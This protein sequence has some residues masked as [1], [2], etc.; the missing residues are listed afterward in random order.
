MT[1]TLLSTPTSTN[2]T[3]IP[4]T[5]WIKPFLSSLFSRPSNTSDDKKNPSVEGILPNPLVRSRKRSTVELADIFK[6]YG[7]A[8]LRT[9]TL[10]RQQ[11]KVLYD[12]THCKSAAVGYHLDVCDGCGHMEIVYNSCRNRHCPKCQRSKRHAWVRARLDQLLPIPYYHTVFTL[13]HRIFPLSLYNKEIVY[14]LL[15]ESA[16]KTLQ[17][18]ASDPKHLGAKIGFYGILHTWGGALWQH[19]HVHFIVT[20]GGLNKKGE[21]VEPKYKDK[22]LF[23]VRALSKVFRGKFIEGLKRAYYDGKLTLPYGSSDLAETDK[24][25]RWIDRLVAKDWV[26][27]LKRPFSGPEDVVRYIGRYTHRVAISN[28]RIL[29]LDKGRVHFLYKD[30][31][32]EKE[33]WSQIH[34]DAREFIRRFMMHVLPPRF[35]RIRHY[36]LFANGKSRLYVNQ[37]RQILASCQKALTKSVGILSKKTSEK[38]KCPACKRGHMVPILVLLPKG[39]IVLKPFFRYFFN[40]EL[41]DTS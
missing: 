16:A 4:T 34:L 21:W 14:T 32:N 22:F 23:P 7:E 19:L 26:V 37:I 40:K 38:I 35:H 28:H 36:G 3:Y 27:Y 12:I 33:Y 13:P 24:F 18:F 8:F 1:T 31:K 15:F 30:Y 9:H 5:N 20:G 17:D 11:H 6:L 10:S 39:L 41:Y 29:S 2:N 25:E